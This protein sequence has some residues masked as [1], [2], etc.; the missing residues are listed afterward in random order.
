M[1]SVRALKFST[2]TFE[3]L[4]FVGVDTTGE[5]P[6]ALAWNPTR[7]GDYAKDCETGRSHFKELQDLMGSESNPLFLCRVLRAQVEGGKWEAIEI[8][9][10]QAMAERL[11]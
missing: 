7:S 5:Y 6:K 11:E 4:S 3:D 1:V 2:A 8:G 10:A 9:F